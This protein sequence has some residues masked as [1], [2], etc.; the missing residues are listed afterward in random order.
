MANDAFADWL[1]VSS[2]E[3]R[4]YV[5]EKG[6]GYYI[7][8]PQKMKISSSGTHYVLDNEGTVHTITK[9]KFMA[10]RFLDR[11]GLTFFNP[12]GAK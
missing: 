9:D 11:N 5:T 2:E 3:H 1:D 7:E 4:E 12:T 6:D 8:K 10:V